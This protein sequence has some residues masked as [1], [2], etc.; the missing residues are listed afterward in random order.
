MKKKRLMLK[1][2][3]TKVIQL[4]AVSDFFFVICSLININNQQQQVY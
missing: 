4:R 2:K 3:V 1:I